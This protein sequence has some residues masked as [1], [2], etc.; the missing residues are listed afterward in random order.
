MQVSCSNPSL[1]FI[2]TN[3]KLDLALNLHLESKLHP[4]RVGV[5]CSILQRD[6]EQHTCIKGSH[7]LPHPLNTV[8]L[9]THPHRMPLVDLNLPPERITWNAAV[10][11]KL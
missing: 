11:K 7:Q 3:S 10:S 4:E 5:P 6:S 1:I 8:P 2:S 9:Y